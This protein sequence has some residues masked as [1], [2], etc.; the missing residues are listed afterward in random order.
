MAGRKQHE[1][2]LVVRIPSSSCPWRAALERWDGWKLALQTR[3]LAPLWRLSASLWCHWGFDVAI[4][5]CKHT[6]WAATHHAASYCVFWVSQWPSR[7]LTKNWFS[8]T[9]AELC[10]TYTNPS[11]LRRKTNDHC[12]FCSNKK[13]YA[14]WCQRGRTQCRLKMPSYLIVSVLVRFL[15]YYLFIYFLNGADP[16]YYLLR[17]AAECSS[18]QL[19]NT[20]PAGTFHGD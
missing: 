15:F 3:Q 19:I 7:V 12:R 18:V 17:C 20:G 11:R 14:G 10:E 13:I 16:S 6:G 5:C 8:V 4:N 9:F 2:R 1:L